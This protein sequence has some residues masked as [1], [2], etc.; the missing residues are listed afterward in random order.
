MKEQFVD[1]E[2]K[3]L[4]PKSNPIVIIII[5]LSAFIFIVLTV[6]VLLR[7]NKIEKNSNLYLINITTKEFYEHYNSGEKFVLLLGRPG[8]SHCVAFKPIVTRVAN[9]KELKVYYLNTDTILSEDDWYFIWELVEQD[10][11]PTLAVIQNKALVDSRSG[12]M[13]RD[14]LIYWFTEV[15]VL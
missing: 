10:G 8:C 1:E 3:D 14:D 4:A 2:F 11:T 5:A 9:E 15:G 12:E 7:G 6:L 13:T